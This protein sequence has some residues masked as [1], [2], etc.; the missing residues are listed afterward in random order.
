M[1]HGHNLITKHNDQPCYC[2]HP[3]ELLYKSVVGK[4]VDVEHSKFLIKSGA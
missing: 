3:V 2:L 4:T 1:S